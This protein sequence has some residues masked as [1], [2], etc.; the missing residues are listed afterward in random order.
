MKL[1]AAYTASSEGP[2]YP[3]YVNVSEVVGKDGQE[4]TVAITLREP[5]SFDP[6]GNAVCG[7][8]V[9][10]KLSVEAWENFLAELIRTA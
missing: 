10:M 7:Q 1:L 8:T 9:Q 6:N 2:Y 3:P 4:M 5:A